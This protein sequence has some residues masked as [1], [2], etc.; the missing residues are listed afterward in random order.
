MSTMNLTG[1]CGSF[2]V[3]VSAFTV[4]I[5]RIKVKGISN[6]NT[7]KMR[8]KALY[9]L[10]ALWVILTDNYFDLKATKHGVWLSKDVCNA[11]SSNFNDIF[12]K[13]HAWNSKRYFK[14]VGIQSVVLSNKKIYKNKY[15]YKISQYSS[16]RP[17]ECTAVKEG[18]SLYNGIKDALDRVGRT[19]IKMYE[20]NKNRHGIAVRSFLAKY[21]PLVLDTDDVLIKIENEYGMPYIYAKDLEDRYKYGKYTEEESKLISIAQKVTR[22][23]NGM[24]SFNKNFYNPSFKY[25]RVYT[26]LHNLPRFIRDCLK[27]NNGE[28]MVEVYDMHGAHTVGF[29][30]MCS[31]WAKDNGYGFISDRIRAYIEDVEADPYR[32]VLNGLFS[33]DRD[34]AKEGTLAYA[35]AGLVDTKYR[36]LFIKR[37]R[38]TGNY[39]E[40]IEFCKSY[41]KI[42]DE[43]CS[44]GI[45]YSEKVLNDLF[46]NVK[47]TKNISYVITGLRFNKLSYYYSH[48]YR[49]LHSE[50]GLEDIAKGRVD[51]NVFSIIVDVAFKA[52]MQYHVE[53]CLINTFGSDIIAVCRG[54]KRLFYDK[55]N[56]IIDSM[57][58][59]IKHSNCSAKLVSRRELAKGNV[60]NASV[61]N[62]AAEGWTM[63]DNIVPE[64]CDKTGCQDIVTIH[65]AI[66]VPES[67]VHKINVK[68]LNMKVVSM[69]IMNVEYAFKHIDAYFNGETEAPFSYVA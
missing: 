18:T 22:A 23:Y 42:F 67:I 13:L 29:L 34:T 12:D 65:D 53:Q 26:P 28:R 61:V 60:P 25:G 62:Q 41:K 9:A 17:I 16:S 15:F 44:E 35:F 5:K 21:E 36:G 27:T 38:A 3:P 33:D 54:I 46:K 39:K 14:T 11:I 45:T 66:L 32:F 37:M 50:A 56:K 49:T 47:I 19:L 63:I 52:M 30:T 6:R 57:V 4:D 20:K 68:E 64:L 8:E 55:A 40:M 48:A 24:S 58:S 10:S 43:Y 59:A 2:S 1:D 7:K 31:V 69:F 51:F